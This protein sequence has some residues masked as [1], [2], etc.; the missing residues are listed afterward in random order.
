VGLVLEKWPLLLLAGAAAVVTVVVQDRAGAT[1]NMDLLTWDRRACNALISCWRYA[2][3]SLWPSGLCAFHPY[4]R[5]LGVL[6]AAI[7]AAALVAVSALALW[8]RRRR[9]WLLVGWF[10]YL[11]ML[12]PVLGLFQV[13]GQAWADRYT[14]LPGIGLALI[15]AWA[16]GDCV[17]RSRPARAVAVAG[18][19]LALAALGTATARQVAVWRDTGSLFTRLLAVS[20]DNLVGARMAHRYLGHDLLAAGRLDL[21]TPHLEQSLGLPVGREAALRDSLRERPDDV[22]L[23][24]TLASLLAREDRVEDGVRDYA[25]ILRRDP[26]DL[27]ALVNVA[28]IRATHT[29]ATH[30]DGAEALRLARRAVALSPEPLAVLQSTLAAACAESGDFPE[31]I[32]A[33]EAAVR[34]AR[35]AGDPLAAAGYARQLARYRRG[36]AYHFAEM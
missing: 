20:G 16:L 13:G 35:A 7:S 24:R 5:D 33:G 21:A 8:Q 23:H 17:G 26:D 3:K 9:P 19:L 2:G 6:A 25:W 12:V 36:R 27:D 34:L 15:V 30:R 29:E 14:Y 1:A 31:A 18:A 28:W 4:G 10:W 22:E 11:G 32:R